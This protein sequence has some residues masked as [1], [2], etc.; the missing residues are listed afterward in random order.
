MAVTAQKNRTN[1]MKI[2]LALV[3]A[4]ALCLTASAAEEAAATNR[5]QPVA[6]E[7]FYQRLLASE[8][9]A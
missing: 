8:L 3:L 5:F 6:L 1:P 2:C 9:I 4:G 7:P